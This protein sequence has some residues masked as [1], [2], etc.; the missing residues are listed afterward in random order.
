MDGQFA[1]CAACTPRSTS[2]FLTTLFLALQMLRSLVEAPMPTGRAASEEGPAMKT[3]W[4]RVL[5]GTAVMIAFLALG[6]LE[7]ALR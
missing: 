6:I 7:V 4:R 3:D 5:V 2:W 1:R